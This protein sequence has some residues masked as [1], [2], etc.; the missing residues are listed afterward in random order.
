V[1]DT[2]TLT[3]EDVEAFQILPPLHYSTPLSGYMVLNTVTR[4]T[5]STPNMTD[6]VDFLLDIPIEVIGDADKPNA[7]T[8]LVNATEDVDY[9][10]GEF[11][12]DLD[13]ILV[14]SD[15]SETLSLVLSNLPPNT[16]P[17]SN[18][19]GG[20]TY[21]G[22]G[23]WQVSQEAI[24][25]LVLP[26]VKHFSGQDPLQY[27][28]L[29]LRAVSQEL[30]GDQETSDPWTVSFDVYPVIDGANADGLAGWNPGS[31]T[32]EEDNEATGSPGISLSGVT[33]HSYVD[34]DGSEQV[35]YY[36]FDLTNVIADAKIQLQLNALLSTSA[37]IDDL[38]AN[39]LTGNYTYEP[40]T[41]VVTVLPGD[42]SSLTFAGTLFKDSNEDFTI[43]VHALVR[44]RAI[45]NGIPY[46]VFKDENA[47]FTVSIKGTP[48]IPTVLC[49]PTDGNAGS[50]LP[51]AIGGDTTDT[52]STLGRT[53]SESVFYVVEEVYI[54]HP[55][56]AFV[57]NDGNVAGLDNGDGAWVFFPDEL[58]ALLGG[59]HFYTWP[60]LNGTFVFD[61]STI[62]AE[63]DQAN[64]AEV[65]VKTVRCNVT[66]VD[67]GGGIDP[68]AP[69]IPSIELGANNGNEDTPITLNVTAFPAS[70]DTTNPSVTVVITDLPPGAKINGAVYNPQTGNYIALGSDVMN[71]DV[72]IDPPLDF[73]GTMFVTVSATAT[74]NY[75]LTNTTGEFLLPI[76]VFQVSDPPGISLT[77]NTGTEDVEVPL[78]ITVTES[79]TD[80]NEVLGNLVYVKLSSGS[81]T[82][83]YPTVASGD[84]DVH[85]TNVEGYYRIPISQIGNLPMTPP[86]NF[87][88]KIFITVVATSEEPTA[89]DFSVSQKTFTVTLDAVA[90]D[91]VLTVPV[92]ASGD[93]DTY[94]PIPMSAVRVDNNEDNG[95][96]SLSTKI[97]DVPQGTL[98][99]KGSN[100]GDGSWTIKVADL[101]TLEVKPP[102]HYAGTMSMKLVGIVVELSNFDET[103]LAAPFTVEVNPIADSFLILTKNVVMLTNETAPLLT[104]FRM[105]DTRGTDIG[106][107]PEEIITVTF[108]N[109]PA[110]LDIGIGAGGTITCHTPPG[111][112]VF[113]GTEAEANALILSPQAG[114]S[115]GVYDINLSAVTTDGTN[116]LPTA[117][118]DDFR[119]YLSDP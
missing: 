23:E 15:T 55:H 56:Y 20:L 59:L 14:D 3:S 62:A 21:L 48:D 52:D 103:Q 17:K 90:D 27:Q 97:T 25:G 93:E 79:D 87:H 57:G 43:P 88:G 4:V 46:D 2:Y 60:G 29:T 16:M 65:A 74:N 119:L 110:N 7:P 22:N 40:T 80:F 33:S 67:A 70:G 24:P 101:P 18:V 38:V 77:P 105:D 32:I 98:F 51:F 31:S 111:T 72:T 78:A 12:G 61:V 76:E 96:E 112:C 85:G 37:T 82:G 30:D 36:E 69:L 45:I 63:N 91:P 94:I 99:N 28:T 19:T 108:T 106:E 35:M 39:Y 107:L 49:S 42:A 83:G 115:P 116:T 84:G 104:N 109:V 8:I 54:D 89:V 44:D 58:A 10:L 86:A 117:I 13:D 71:G 53:Q 113:S 66:V 64:D 41:K 73:S 102:L 92:A 114:I 100:N 47:L 1:N 26:A 95:A 6:V 11:I 9:P 5:D 81:L 34:T 68:I 50:V 118:L 75:T